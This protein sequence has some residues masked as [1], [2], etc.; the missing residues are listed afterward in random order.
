MPLS[1]EDFDNQRDNDS[2]NIICASGPVASIFC[3]S[4]SSFEKWRARFLGLLLGLVS[5]VFFLHS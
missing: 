2:D 3:I 4:V 1:G 5:G